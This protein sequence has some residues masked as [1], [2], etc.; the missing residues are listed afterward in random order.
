VGI[1]CQKKKYMTHESAVL[2]L[3]EI[4]EKRVRMGR[5]SGKRRHEKYCYKC[6][7]CGF[8]H[9]TSQPPRRREGERNG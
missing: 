5:K 9:L 3:R 8:Y 1:D 7:M 6:K 2:K 4:R